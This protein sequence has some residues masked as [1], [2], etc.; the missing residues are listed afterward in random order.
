MIKH[1]KKTTKERM[2]SKSTKTIMAK[3]A[4]MMRTMSVASTETLIHPLIRLKIHKNANGN[5]FKLSTI[6]G[7]NEATPMK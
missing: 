2:T 4:V 1:A 3:E 5:D 7:G 6:V